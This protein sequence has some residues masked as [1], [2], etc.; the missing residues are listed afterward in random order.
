[1]ENI[2]NKKID[3]EIYKKHCLEM[4]LSFDEK[5]Y[6]FC[7]NMDYDDIYWSD[8]PK[9]DFNKICKRYDKTTLLGFCIRRVLLKELNDADVSYLLEENLYKVF[10]DTLLEFE[11]EDTLCDM[12]VNMMI[13]QDGQFE[14]YYPGYLSRDKMY[15]EWLETLEDYYPAYLINI[16]SD[17]QTYSEWLEG[18]LVSTHPEFE[19]DF[20]R[21]E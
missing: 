19:K 9:K 10:D 20:F 14:D 21:G 11:L 18:L 13:D 7:I 15:N 6:L 16:E 4:D 8:V 17:N 12:D 5:E 2:N 3:I 1:M